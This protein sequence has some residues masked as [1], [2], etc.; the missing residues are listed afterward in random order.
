MERVRTIPGEENAPGSKL[1][2]TGTIHWKS[3][4]T[5]ATNSTGFYGLPGGKRDPVSP[6]NGIFTLMGE[7]GHFWSSSA[8][9]Q[10]TSDGLLRALL[11]TS[12]NLGSGSNVKGNGY[13]VRCIK[14]N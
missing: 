4:N 2:D 10:Y 7:I 12:S 14:D 11:N 13:S 9:T 1:K 6:D 5:G 3:P 8:S